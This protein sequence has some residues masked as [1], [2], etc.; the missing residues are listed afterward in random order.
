MPENLFISDL[1]L[2]AERPATLQMF[3]DFLRERPQPGDCLYILG[4]L[5][6]VWVGDDDNAPLAQRVRQAFAALTSRGVK[7]YLQRGNRDFMMGK[8][9]MRETGAELLP[10]PHL[11]QVAGRPTLL[12]HGD[13]LCSDDIAYLKARRRLRNPLFQWLVRHRSLEARRRMAAA[14][15][16]RSGETTAMTA[17][18]IMDAN[19]QTIV[20]YLKQY[21]A[22][23][24]IHGHTHRP[25]VHEHDLGNGQHARRYVLDE[26]HEDH[27]ALWVDD[28]NSLHREAV[29]TG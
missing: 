5:F 15:R 4:D 26:W 22:A 27:A 9:L 6:D 10:D 13:L 24:I 7:L 11:M 3:L 16:Q 8:R 2:A 1:H 19:G 14:Y 20:S 23:Q 25:A 12:M 29:G 18:Q 28:G 17:A 21:R